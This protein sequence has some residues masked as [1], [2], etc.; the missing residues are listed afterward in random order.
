LADICRRELL[1]MDKIEVLLTPV[2]KNERIASVMVNITMIKPELLQ[3]API[4]Q[5][6]KNVVGVLFLTF[7][8][9][10]VLKDDAGDLDY[11]VTQKEIPKIIMEEYHLNRKICGDVH[12]CYEV[13]LKPVG[14][15]P[16]FDLGYED[17]GMDGS[18]MSFMPCFE[19]KEYRFVV[20]W[21]L[22]GLPKGFRGIWSLGEGRIETV[23]NGRTLAESF[24]YAGNIKGVKK[25]NCGFYWFENPGLPGEEV[26]GFVM[27]L[28]ERMAEFFQDGGEPY[29]VFSRKVPEILTGRNKI[30]G[31]ALT[32]SFLYLYPEENPPKEKPL[33]FL[34]PHEMVHNWPKLKDEPFGTCTWYVEGTAEYYSIIL[35]DRFGM[36]TKEELITQLNKRAKDYYE[37]PRIQ[38]TNQFAGEHLFIDGEATLVPYGR[39]FFYLLHMDEVIRDATKGEKSLDDVVLAILRRT[40]TTEECKNDV[41]LEEV[42]RIAGIDV[43][44]EFVEMQNGKVFVPALSSLKTSV[45]VV[46]STGTQRETGEECVLYQFE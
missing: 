15:N 28:F 2:W 41:W 34:F 4:F 25:N 23:Q 45:N 43:S 18:G 19:E 37:N 30:G 39:G 22:S 3:D 13:E 24:Y 26:G 42:K 16:A 29:Q 31:I 7:S 21:E 33:K 5:F 6:H 40:R 35:P 12:I 20:D 46:K 27:N 44:D 10:V 14:K 9:K 17:G 1:N 11:S 8:Q 32:R 38:V 36:I